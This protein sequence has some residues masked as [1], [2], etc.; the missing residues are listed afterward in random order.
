MNEVTMMIE[1]KRAVEQDIP[2]IEDILLDT[3]VWLD[4]IDKPLWTQ[5]QIKWER[6]SK[7]F[8]ASDFYIAYLDGNPAA[9][10]AVVDHDP[11]FWADIPKG[12]SL[13]IHKLAVKRFVAGKGLSDA[14]IIHAKSMCMDRSISELRL[15]CHSLIL[16]QRAVY[17][18]YGFVCVD[19]KILHGKYHTAFYLCK[20]HDTKHLYHYYDKSTPPFRTLTSLPFEEAKRIMGEDSWVDNFLNQRYGRDT[21]LRESF[22]AIGGKPIRTA[23]VYFTLGANEGMKTWF[24]YP[25]WIRIRVADFDLDTVSFT[26]G[27]SFAIFNTSL[28]TGEEYWG[29]TFKYEDIL[30]IINKYGLPEDPPYHMGKRIFPKDKHINHCLKFIEAHIWSDDVLDKYLI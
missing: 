22:I 17:E 15:D 11:Q 27:D 29:K 1:I 13:F 24:E 8:D 30:K 4:S 9:C 10:M 16:K 20:V 28:N 19:E 21:T 3:V 26:Y 12:D 2:I 6:L 7:D 25:D 14:L 18:R 23:P 5:N